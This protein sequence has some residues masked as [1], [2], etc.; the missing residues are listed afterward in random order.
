MHEF[1]AEAFAA[2]GQTLADLTRDV[3]GNPFRFVSID[4][5]TVVAFAHA[6]YDECAFDRMP[7]HAFA[8]EDAGCTNADILDHCRGP[9]PH[10]RGCWVVDLLTGRL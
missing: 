4:P 3:M 8:L 2:L 9:G 7:I 6:I 10:V 5:V 1:D